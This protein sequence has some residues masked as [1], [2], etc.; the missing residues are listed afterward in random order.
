MEEDAG[1][2]SRRRGPHDQGVPSVHVSFG[3]RQ[4]HDMGSVHSKEASLLKA[5]YVTENYVEM[6]GSLYPVR[7]DRFPHDNAILFEGASP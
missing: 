1:N 7:I 2:T 5:P 6:P 4:H 3:K